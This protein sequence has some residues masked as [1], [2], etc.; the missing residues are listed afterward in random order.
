MCKT[1]GAPVLQ[2][3]VEVSATLYVH[4]CRMGLAIM[5]MYNLCT[6]L[7]TLQLVKNGKL[8]H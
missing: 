5:W 3:Y 4:R 2:K 1:R 8:G 6:F 7:E